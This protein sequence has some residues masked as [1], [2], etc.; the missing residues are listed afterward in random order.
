MKLQWCIIILF[1]LSGFCCGQSDQSLRLHITE[2]KLRTS[3]ELQLKNDSTGHNETEEQQFLNFNPVITFKEAKNI[4]TIDKDLEDLSQLTIFTVYQ[5][6][7]SSAVKGLWG[8]YNEESRITLTTEQIAISGKTLSYE[9]GHGT[10]PILNTYIQS[11]GSGSIQSDPDNPR[12]IVGA[13]SAGEPDAFKGNIAE[14]MVFDKVLRAKQR[15]VIETSLALKYGITLDNTRDYISSDEAVI[16]SVD[17]DAGYANRIFGIGRDDG[18]GLC[19]KQSHSTGESSMITIGFGEIAGSNPENSTELPNG[20]FLILGD[21]NLDPDAFYTGTSNTPVP[22]MARHWKIQVTGDE[23]SE[24]KTTLQL[25]LSNSFK[26]TQMDESDY[27]MAVDRSGKGTFLPENTRYFKASGLEAYILSFE[28]IQWD[29]DMSGSDVF[30]FA[31]KKDL[32]VSLTEE[33]PMNCTP[34]EKGKLYF[35]A[36]GGVPP[37][38]YQLLASTAIKDEWKSTDTEYPEKYIDNLSPDIY[39]L[40]VTDNAGAQSEIQYDLKAPTPVSVN[41][42]EDRRLQSDTKEILLDATII[43]D[44]EIAYEWSS[45]NGFFSDQPSITVT[46]PGR[47]TVHAVFGNGCR[48]SDSIDIEENHVQLFSLF[49][50]PS[51]DGN[52]KIHIELNDI[53]PIRVYVFDMTGK[54]LYSMSGK[55]QSAYDMSGKPITSS[56]IYNVVLQAAE[57]NVSRK[58]VVE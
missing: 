19:Q 38:N 18:T 27:L 53:Q 36:K 6:D 15:Q 40:K 24:L 5:S 46:R 22:T 48:A 58:L 56:G 45:D 8:I 33:E 28:G 47:Y 4:L 57:L 23:A 10:T 35:D 43:A 11:Y 12:V 17:E 31:L 13:C 20:N 14:I 52:Y 44:E 2:E 50:N 37:Y 55:G 39:T 21:D 7:N 16:Y 30:T 51:R 1:G 42:G 49:P 25:D 9:G 34:G 3:G 26:A 41:L 32:E 54:L 29:S